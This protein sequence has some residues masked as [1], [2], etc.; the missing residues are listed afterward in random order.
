MVIVLLVSQFVLAEDYMPYIDRAIDQKDY[1][2]ALLFLQ[3]QK[4]LTPKN[5]DVFL[6][7]GRAYEG[8]G[9]NQLA[10]KCYTRSI[11]YDSTYYL[12]LV[13]RSCVYFAEHNNQKAIYDIVSAIQIY[14]TDVQKSQQECAVLDSLFYVYAEQDFTFARSI[15]DSL[16]QKGEV[17]WNNKRPKMYLKFLP[18]DAK[19]NLFV[20]DVNVVHNDSSSSKIYKL[21]DEMPQFIGGENCLINY[22]V[23]SVKYPIPAFEKG[24]EGRV[25]VEF[26]VRKDGSIT[27][28]EVVRAVDKYL[29]EEAIRIVKAM[30]RWQPGK[31]HG[32]IVD[33]KYTVPIVFRIAR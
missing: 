7:F 22:L 25:I 21:V 3:K 11:E 15:V 4:S 24:I 1:D 28:I 18:D 5:T 6:A 32:E 14:G 26:T 12:P 17:Q 23:Q 19:E 31:M 13:Y 30:P 27:D 9:E 29:D 8:K 10:I 33:C 2:K 16:I 20:G